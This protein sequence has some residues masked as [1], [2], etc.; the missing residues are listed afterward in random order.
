VR[1]SESNLA[2]ASNVYYLPAPVAVDEPTPVPSRIGRLGRIWWRLRFA[3]AGIRL[4]LRPAPASLFTEEDTLAMLEGH[5]ELV[6]RRPRQARPARVID[7]DA[8]RTRLRTA[9][10]AH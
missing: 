10:A 7:F 8:A 1:D 3:V 4:A 2:S 5:A 9:T 6:E